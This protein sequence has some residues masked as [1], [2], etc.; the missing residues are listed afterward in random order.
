M[1]GEAAGLPPRRAG[2]GAAQPSP[3]GQE[4]LARS[5]RLGP[6]ALPRLLCP[7]PGAGRGGRRR[8]AP[9]SP[10]RAGLWQEECGG[11][12]VLP[13]R[14][15][16]A[17]LFVWGAPGR[18]RARR[19][20]Q[21]RC[22]E[23][24]EEPSSPAAAW[25]KPRRLRARSASPPGGVM[26]APGRQPAVGDRMHMWPAAAQWSSGK[27]GFEKTRLPL[28]QDHGCVSEIPFFSV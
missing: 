9:S 26:P 24:G 23:R 16:A 12:R 7:R 3:A 13:L 6:A 4:P 10:P 22:R 14:P 25:P 11:G 8:K 20:P 19:F 1:P 2:C 18:G 27:T 28:L 17:A 15:A 21:H 5:P